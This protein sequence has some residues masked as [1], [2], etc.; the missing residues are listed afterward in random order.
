M[1]GDQAA[2]IIRGYWGIEN[3]LHWRMD[4]LFQ[5][6]LSLV[7]SGH[8]AENLSVLRRMALNI[9]KGKEKR[10]VGVASKRRRAGWDDRYMVELLAQFISEPELAM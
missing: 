1:S 2:K 5:E 7:D 3:G 9:L 6:D 8:A 10:G 4:V